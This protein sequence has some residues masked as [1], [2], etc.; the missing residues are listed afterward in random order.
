LQVTIH[1]IRRLTYEKVTFYTVKVDDG[2]H[3]FEDF[4]RRLSKIAKYR[5]LLAKLFQLIERMGLEHGA[6]DFFFKYYKADENIPGV[7]LK[8]VS[9]IEVPLGKLELIL[10]CLRL[11]ES[12]VILLNGD[13]K[14]NSYLEKCNSKKHYEL[15]SWLSK[16]I[17][18]AILKA[19]NV[20][21][22][23]GVSELADNTPIKII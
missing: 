20:D 22:V 2:A 6:K 3:E 5:L 13:I 18:S 1:R 19:K 9:F 21:V 11:N 15:A 7:N 12:T 17:E 14:T 4:K 16:N 23:T 8:K 10:Y